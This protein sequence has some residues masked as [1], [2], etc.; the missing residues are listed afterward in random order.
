[1]DPNA[2]N[3]A[4]AHH[5][6]NSQGLVYIRTFLVDRPVLLQCISTAGDNILRNDASHYEVHTGKI[7]GVF[8]KFLGVV[9][10]LVLTSDVFAHGLADGDEQRT[11]TTGGVIYFERLLLLMVLGH[12]LRHHHSNLVGCIEL[13]CL[14]ASMGGKV[15]DKEL[16]DIAQHVV[17][18]RAI[19]RY[20]LDEFD[21]SFQSLGLCRRIVAQFAQTLAQGFEDAGIH[22]CEVFTHQT[23]EVTECLA[24]RCDAE[25]GICKPSIEQILIFDEEADVFLT[26]GNGVLHIHILVVLYEFHQLIF[27][28]F[29]VLDEVFHL[30][31]GQELVEDKSQNVVLIL[32]GI[33]L[34]AHIVRRCPYSVCQ[35]L[36]VHILYSIIFLVAKLYL[37]M[38]CICIKENDF[39]FSSVFNHKVASLSLDA[40]FSLLHLLLQK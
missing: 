33:N 3:K 36:L 27:F 22:R 9:L 39:N 29:A 18:L 11:G 26:L 20:V 1:M 23:L 24:E 14:F 34:V 25:L 5:G 10:H 15:A 6:I 21:E 38:Q 17:V 2:A 32:I 35:L 40:I 7:V 31:V 28:P 16:I 12:N 13:T 19:S 30:C 37:S 4:G 8:L